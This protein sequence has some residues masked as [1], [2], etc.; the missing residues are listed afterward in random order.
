M[1]KY[2]LRDIAGQG[3]N[4]EEH[5]TRVMWKST[6]FA[7]VHTTLRKHILRPIKMAETLLN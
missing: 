5:R 2:F 6:S 4:V 7:I 1:A 3:K